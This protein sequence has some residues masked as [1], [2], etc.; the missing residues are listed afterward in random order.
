MQTIIVL[1]LA[2]HVLSGVFWAGSTFTLARTGGAGAQKLFRPQM[3]SAAVAVLTGA[4]LWWLLHTGG[5]PDTT[6]YI[7]ASGA[8]AA[9][10]AAV[11]QGAWGLSAASK[12]PDAELDGAAQSA[13]GAGAA[14]RVAAALLAVTVICMAAAR[15]I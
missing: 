5:A 9:V 1:A 15:Y 13:H 3:G 7:L 8:L 11:V 14:Q 10:V 12:P 4:F 2:L 6:E